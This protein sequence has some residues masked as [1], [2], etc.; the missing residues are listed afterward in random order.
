VENPRHFLIQAGTLGEKNPAVK[1]KWQDL[2]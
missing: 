2:P 1:N